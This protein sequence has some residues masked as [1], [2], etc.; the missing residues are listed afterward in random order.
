[1]RL[2]SGL[3][4]VGCPESAFHWPRRADEHVDAKGG[5]FVVQSFG[6]AL[7]GS[8]DHSRHAGVEFIYML[9]SKVRYDAPI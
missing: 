4:I 9:S 6:Q 5:E 3:V 2:P 7:N 8:F 1:M